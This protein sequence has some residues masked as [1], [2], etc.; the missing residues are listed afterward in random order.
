MDFE[1]IQSNGLTNTTAVLY[2]CK[3]GSA[4]GIIDLNWIDE[5]GGKGEAKAMASF[6]KLNF[7]LELQQSS[8]SRLQIALK[9]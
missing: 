6:E 9:L 5:N 2:K 8:S 7:Y 3:E 4:L 1:F